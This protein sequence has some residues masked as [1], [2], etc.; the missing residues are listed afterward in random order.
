LA[1]KPMNRQLKIMKLHAQSRVL[2]LLIGVACIMAPLSS[3]SAQGALPLKAPEAS[4][5]IE[6]REYS[7]SE[8]KD[9][10]LMLWFLSTWC[11]TCIQAVKA[12]EAKKS[13]L[14]ASGM[15]IVVL[16]NHQNGGYPGPDIHDFINQFAASLSDTSNWMIG[17]ASAAMGVTYNPRRYPD[18]YFL[19]DETGMVVAVEGAPAVTLDIIMNFASENAAES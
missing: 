10:R 11:S 14:E 6:G 1:E 7:I 17:D 12:L 4:F 16:K 9:R 8:F 2:A 19:I 15:Q 5:T 13:E 18:V 3:V